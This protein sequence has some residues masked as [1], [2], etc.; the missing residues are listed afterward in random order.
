MTFT[1]GPDGEVSPDPPSVRP[2][3]PLTRRVDPA[4]A[5]G[6]AAGVVVLTW[7][8]PELRILPRLLG[9]E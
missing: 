3:A 6:I 8:A 5:L 1:Q 7:L 2:T 9:R 4:V